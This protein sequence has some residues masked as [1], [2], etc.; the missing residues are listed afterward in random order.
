MGG[1]YVLGQLGHLR[2][3][4]KKCK[5]D[6]PFQDKICHFENGQ[7]CQKYSVSV[8]WGKTESDVE[9]L[10][11]ILTTPPPPPPPPPLQ[12]FLKGNKCPGG[13][14]R[15]VSRAFK[16]FNLFCR[17]SVN[18][19]FPDIIFGLQMLSNGFLLERNVWKI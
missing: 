4:K 19:G 1:A 17:Q 6:R 11:M 12:K 8:V 13:W 7:M 16:V 10:I 9:L 2:N 18:K 15:G 5:K 14:G 3:R